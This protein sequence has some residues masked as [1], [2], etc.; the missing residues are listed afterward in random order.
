MT[1]WIDHDGYVDFTRTDNPARRNE[2]DRDDFV[3]STN[4][5]RVKTLAESTTEGAEE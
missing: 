5:A 1:A 4:M 3:L 2:P